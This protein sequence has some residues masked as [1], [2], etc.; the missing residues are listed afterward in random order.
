MFEQCYIL[1]EYILLV[2]ACKKELVEMKPLCHLGCFL[3]W[4]HIIQSYTPK[5]MFK[6]A[7]HFFMSIGLDPMTSTFW[8]KSMIEKPRDRNVV[9]HG[10][11]EDF[12]QEGDYRQVYL[13]KI[14]P[15]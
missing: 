15:K 14:Y 8:S 11:A 13:K 1:P 7:E 3:H 5:Q 10:S 9:C 12:F 6:M 4:L 2:I